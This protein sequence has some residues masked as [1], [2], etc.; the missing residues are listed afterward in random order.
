MKPREIYYLLGRCL[1]M[2]DFPEFQEEI[3][4]Q[5]SQKDFPW[6]TFVFTGSNHL[7]LPALYYKFH[8]C[9]LLDLLPQDLCDHLESIFRMNGERNEGIFKQALAMNKAFKGA[10]I[11]PVF[12][13]GVAS[14]A[15]GIY[16]HP[17][18]RMLSD[19]DCVFSGSALYDAV[20]ILRKEGYTHANYREEDLPFMHHFPTLIGPGS[21]VPVDLHFEPVAGGYSRYLQSWEDRTTVEDRPHTEL[22]SFS[23]GDMAVLNFLHSQIQDKGD[24]FAKVSLKNLYEFYQINRSGGLPLLSPGKSGRIAGKLENYVA[25]AERTFHPVSSQ[26]TQIKRGTRIFLKRFD[27][28]KSNKFYA[29]LNRI[30]RRMLFQAVYYL[31]LLFKAVRQEKYRRYVLVRFTDWAWPRS[32][33]RHLHRLFSRKPIR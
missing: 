24:Y 15:R 28:N 25:L 6:E 13:K 21:A 16:K 3:S 1:V 22:D 29:G 4:R 33:L 23:L 8:A 10:S 17:A 20:K 9:G 26:T 32:H 27:Q 31:K 18:E 12:I 7:V 30:G 14:L 11:N 5:L 19:I 2:D